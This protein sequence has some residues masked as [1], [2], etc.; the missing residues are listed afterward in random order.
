MNLWH[1]IPLGDNAPEEINVIIEVPKGSQNKYEIEKETG[2]VHLDRANY[3][4]A[5]YPVEYGFAPQ[6]Y[7]EDGDAIDVLVLA[8]FPIPTGILVKVRPVA[9]MDM[10][11]TGESDAKII[12]VPVNDKRWDEVHDLG[13]INKHTLKEIK[14]FFETYKH[15]KGA[16]VTVPGFKGKKEALEALRRSVDLYKKKFDK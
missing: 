3:S 12:G 11:D 16:E 14:H 9:F 8:S 1:D 5:A 10:I 4:A 2:L 7:W 15:L 13:D 6:T